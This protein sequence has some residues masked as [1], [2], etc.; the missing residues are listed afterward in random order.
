MFWTHTDRSSF[1]SVTGGWHLSHPHHDRHYGIPLHLVKGT[2]FYTSNRGRSLYNT[3]SSHRWSNGNDKNGHTYCASKTM[4]VGGKTLVRVPFRGMANRVNVYAACQSYNMVPVLDHAH[5]KHYGREAWAY[6]HWHF[7]HPHHNMHYGIPIYKVSGA[8]FYTGGAYWGRT[9]QN[10][11]Y[12][13]GHR[14]SGNHDKNGE[15]FCVNWKRNTVAGKTNWVGFQMGSWYIGDRGH[16]HF[17]INQPHHHHHYLPQMLI[18]RD[19]RVYRRHRVHR[20]S[21]GWRHHGQTS[22]N[23]RL[24]NWYIGQRDGHHFVIS[25]ITTSLC[26]FLVRYDSILFFHPKHGRAGN[27]WRHHS[28]SDHVLEF[29]QWLVGPRDDNHFG[30]THKPTGPCTF[31]IRH[32]GV[33][34]Y[35]HDSGKAPHGWRLHPSQVG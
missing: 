28:R 17:V 1:S 14:W 33:V 27:N 21:N 25:K 16:G 20:P 13:R 18:R 26:Q 10:R 23:I 8:Y 5:Y 4:W 29:G 30:I 31:L 19:S 32:D 3:G 6:Q 34:Y 35:S 7:S 11:G 9:L 22:Y 24:G 12:R 15:T 2:F